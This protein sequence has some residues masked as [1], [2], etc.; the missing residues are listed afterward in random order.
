MRLPIG[1]MNGID[2]DAKHMNY[3]VPKRSTKKYL[4]EGFWV[5]CCIRK[6]SKIVKFI[7]YTDG[8]VLNL[9]KTKCMI[10]SR[11]ISEHISTLKSELV[12][13]IMYRLKHVLP[14]KTRI[15]IYRSFVQSLLL[16]SVGFCV[17][18]QY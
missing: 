6:V 9:L 15:Q 16:T 3:G 4:K 7:L 14:L 12:L 17:A 8:L 18:Y 2:S 5:H 10:F 1:F 13:Y 11:Q